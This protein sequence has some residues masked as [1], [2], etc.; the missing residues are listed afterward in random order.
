[1]DEREGRR[2]IQSYDNKKQQKY[3]CESNFF[4]KGCLKKNT[5]GFFQKEIGSLK[6]S[7]MKRILIL[8]IE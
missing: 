4:V 1:M 3:K 6:E 2:R 7:L 5:R 8:G